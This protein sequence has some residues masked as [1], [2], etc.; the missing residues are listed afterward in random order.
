M[1]LKSQLSTARVSL[2]T[3]SRKSTWKPADQ[4]CSWKFVTP[5]AEGDEEFNY[6]IMNSTFIKKSYLFISPAIKHVGVCTW[7]TNK[8]SF[9]E[10]H[11]EAG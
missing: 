5:K 10:G 6:F 4:T 9:E 3:N 2:T 11:I 1:C 7:V 8:L